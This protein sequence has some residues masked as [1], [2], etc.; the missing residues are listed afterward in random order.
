MDVQ[1]WGDYPVAHYSR[2]DEDTELNTLRECLL[3]VVS[4]VSGGIGGYICIDTSW[5]FAVLVSW[6]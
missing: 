6:M 1:V 4:Y 2:E 3:K 5:H